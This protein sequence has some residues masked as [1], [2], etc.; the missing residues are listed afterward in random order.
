MKWL[1]IGGMAALAG[2]LAIGLA[3]SLG[4]WGGWTASAQ[5]TFV[6]NSDAGTGDPA[7]CNAP[8]FPSVSDIETVIEDTDVANGDTLVLCPGTYTAG[9]AAG[10]VEVDKKLTIQGLA[11]ADR[12]QIV[13]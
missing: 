1:R 2:A 5:D 11:S 3:L 4:L 8:D 13:I 6:V 7:P 12:D 10:A 9:A